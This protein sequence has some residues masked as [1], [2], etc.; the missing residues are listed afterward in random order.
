MAIIQP[1]TQNP[2]P[3]TSVSNFDRMIQLAD[4]TFAVRNDPQQLDV[5]EDV[6]RTLLTIHPST[7]SEQVDGDGPVA[8][9]LLI[10]TSEETMRKFID[11]KIGERELL[12]EAAATKNFEAIYL[13]S[14]LVLP[15][16]RNKGIA[17]QLT[18]KATNELRKSF[19]IRSLY[20]WPFSKEGDRLSAELA[21]KLHLPLFKRLND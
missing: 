17:S 20:V 14:A 6:I 8:W 4:D 3:E 16:F 18:L 1:E 11:K 15:E 19:P 2:K 13:C 21:S 7:L 9:I 10:P 5:D 12:S